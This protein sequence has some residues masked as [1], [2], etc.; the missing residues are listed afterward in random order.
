MGE[1]MLIHVFSSCGASLA[2]VSFVVEMA[3]DWIRSSDD[4]TRRCG[5]GLRSVQ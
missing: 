5:Y 4:V 3:D 1:G 2:K